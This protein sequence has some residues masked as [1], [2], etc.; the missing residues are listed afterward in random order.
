[1]LLYSP[2]SKFSFSTH[3]LFPHT[4]IYFYISTEFSIVC[5]FYNELLKVL[6][7]SPCSKYKEHEFCI[8]DCVKRTYWIKNIYERAV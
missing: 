2:L 1:M 8:G 5:V 7:L 3:Y 6:T 4:C